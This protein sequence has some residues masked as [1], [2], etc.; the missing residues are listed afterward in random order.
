[1]QDAAE[2]N[3]KVVSRQRVGRLI[4][5]LFAALVGVGVC[6]RGAESNPEPP[7]RELDDVTGETLKYTIERA[8]RGS[9]LLLECGPNSRERRLVW[10]LADHPQAAWRNEM[11]RFVPYTPGKAAWVPRGGA[12]V[13]DE[14][15]V[16]VYARMNAARQELQKQVKARRARFAHAGERTAEPGDPAYASHALSLIGQYRRLIGAFPLAAQQSAMEGRVTEV[17]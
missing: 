8:G 12:T 6:A 1:M 9:G 7:F 11:T 4:A 5:S 17:G 3:Q 13:F 14:D 16:S 2:R 15:Q 10:C